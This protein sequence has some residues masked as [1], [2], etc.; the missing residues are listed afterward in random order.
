M[1]YKD[2]IYGDVE[3]ENPV[4]LEL[5]ESKAIQRLKKVNQYGPH[6]LRDK[7][8]DTTR[9]EHSVGC[10]ILL[11]KFG[12]S[13]EAQAAGLLHDVSHGAFSHLMDHILDKQKVQNWHDETF[14][15]FVMKS[16]IPP[17]LQKHGLDVKELFDKGKWKIATQALPDLSADKIDYG[18]RDSI[19][20]ENLTPEDKDHILQN[21]C[22]PAS[23]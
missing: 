10:A 15:K 13:L 18:L 16:D 11:E 9:F 14:E 6:Y 3:I 22:G 23:G 12:A 4:I 8:L 1:I 5:I 7:K 21:H 20:Y 2:K 19:L 17:I